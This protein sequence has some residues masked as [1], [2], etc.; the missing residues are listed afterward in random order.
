[1]VEFGIG[2]RTT[3]VWCS[4][5]PVLVSLFLG[6]YI[7]VLTLLRPFRNRLDESLFLCMRF[8]E[9]VVWICYFAAENSHPFISFH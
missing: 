2:K 9:Y 4:V 5:V 6:F 8:R 3:L 7:F 1:M